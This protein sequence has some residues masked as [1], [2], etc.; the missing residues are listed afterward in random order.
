MEIVQQRSKQIGRKKLD[1]KYHNDLASNKWSFL[2]KQMPK[3]RN[4]NEW[5]FKR[6]Q[7]RS[8]A[9]LQPIIFQDGVIVACVDKNSSLG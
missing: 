9:R 8:P 1:F 5:I 3:Q 4:S 2:L 7:G 6:K